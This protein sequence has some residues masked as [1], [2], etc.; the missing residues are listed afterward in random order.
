[1]A[2]WQNSDGLLVRFGTDIGTRGNKAGVTSTLGKRKELV[3]TVSLPGLGASGTSY[4]ADLNNDGTLDGFSGLDAFLPSGVKIIEC[5]VFAST[6]AAGGTNY[7]IGTYQVGGTVDDA[8]G[9]YT[10]AGAQGAQVGTKLT[11]D[12]YVGVLVSGT[13]TAGVLEIRVVYETV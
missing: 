1:M 6:A 3:L 8:D 11:A 10:T 4:T 7:Q 5:S 2:T 9:L 12:R 13:Y